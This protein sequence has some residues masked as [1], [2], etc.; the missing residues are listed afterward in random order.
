MHLRRPTPIAVFIVPLAALAVA[1]CGGDSGSTGPSNNPYGLTASGPGV[2]SVTPL[3]T[4]T[5]FA[6]TPLGALAPPGHVLPTD[7]IYLYFVDPWTG[8]QQFNDCRRARC[9]WSR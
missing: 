5:L 7:H 8:Q 3:D 4:S 6:A 9:C 1:S 2:L